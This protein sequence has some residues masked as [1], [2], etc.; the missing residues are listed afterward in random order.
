MGSLEDIEARQQKIADGLAG[1]AVAVQAVY[2]E[3]RALTGSGG[4]TSDAADRINAK[5]TLIEE[6]AATILVDDPAT[7][8]VEEPV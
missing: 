1:I 4:I 5:L 7:P 8:P 2:D 3:V 6:A